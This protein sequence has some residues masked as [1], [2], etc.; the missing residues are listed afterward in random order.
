MEAT[1]RSDFGHAGPRAIYIGV[2]IDLD[3]LWHGKSTRLRRRGALR[4]CGMGH[5]SKVQHPQPDCIVD[6]GKAGPDR[7]QAVH[8]ILPW[9]RNPRPSMTSLVTQLGRLGLAER[10]RDTTDARVVRVVITDAGRELL[11]ER[12]RAGAE[13]LTKLI[14]ALDEQDLARLTPGLPAVRRLVDA[15]AKR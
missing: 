14:D 1:E 4:P 13:A 3:M 8:P 2:T 11:R 9:L 10:Q 5:P 12:R 6:V 15:V 7:A